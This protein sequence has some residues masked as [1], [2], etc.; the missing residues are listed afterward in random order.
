MKVLG[1]WNIKLKIQ[2]HTKIESQIK[3]LDNLVRL[4]NSRNSI[5]HIF[6]KTLFTI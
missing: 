4:K 3:L 6:D 1:M 5:L 2:I